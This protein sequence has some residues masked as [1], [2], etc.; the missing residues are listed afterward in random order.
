MIGGNEAKDETKKTIEQ[1][2]GINLDDLVNKGTKTEQ[3]IEWLVK[4]V[5]VLDAKISKVLER[6]R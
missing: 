1:M 3:N 5:Q 2:L 4:A 6:I